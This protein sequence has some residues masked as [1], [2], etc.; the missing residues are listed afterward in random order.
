M[1]RRRLASEGRFRRRFGFG[2]RRVLLHEFFKGPPGLRIRRISGPSANCERRGVLQASSPPRQ[3]SR[4]PRAGIVP[5]ASPFPERHPL[6]QKPSGGSVLRPPASR[7]L[8]NCESVSA[9]P[10]PRRCASRT[11]PIGSWCPLAAPRHSARFLYYRNALSGSQG[12][13]L[14]LPYRWQWRL[15]RWKNALRGFFGGEQQPR[16]KLCPVCGALVGVSATRCHEC[17]ASLRFSLAALSK[18]L[19]G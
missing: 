8:R 3:A 12:G 15:E 19:S 1:R 2:A 16:P 7:S 10:L 18:K 4:T 14:P 11:L 13:R 5:C 17:G 9:S 6:A